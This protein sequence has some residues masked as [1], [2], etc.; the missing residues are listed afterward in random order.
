M[1][2][3]T[4]KIKETLGVALKVILAVAAVALIVITVKNFTG[5][6]A[7]I[8]DGEE[9]RQEFLSSL[10]W[11]VSKEPT[12]CVSAVIPDAWNE[13]Y[14]EY[15]KLQLQQGF[16][17]DDYRGKNVIIYTYPVYNYEGYPDNIVATLI[18]YENRLIGG[19]IQNCELGGFMQGLVKTD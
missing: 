4:Y 15:N 2:V 11:E 6:K 19:D 18:T 7:I 9:K 14:E 3:K 8:L 10:G 13:V 12:N 16:D 5:K 17:L 1:F